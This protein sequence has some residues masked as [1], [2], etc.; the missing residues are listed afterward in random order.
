MNKDWEER[1]AWVISS[2]PEWYCRW[3][4]GV[5]IRRLAQGRREGRADILLWGKGN[6]RGC[7]MDSAIQCHNQP[8][9]E[10]VTGRGG[11]VVHEEHL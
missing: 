4:R 1:L 10:A 9:G 2:L 7:G 3:Q 8:A 5:E 6:S 11:R